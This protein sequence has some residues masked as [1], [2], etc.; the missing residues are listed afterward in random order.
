MAG[1]QSS[2]DEN[3]TGRTIRK[4]IAALAAFLAVT[5][6]N[7]LYQIRGESTMFSNSVLALLAFGAFL[8]LGLRFFQER[9]S[10]R[11]AVF[12]LA[13]GFLFAAL[14]AFGFSLNYT[15]TI[16]NP[17]VFP[18]L[19]CL[20]PFF[21]VCTGFGL[22]AL[23]GGG[24]Q[25]KENGLWLAKLSDRQFYL[26]C[27]SAL[28][29]AW[30]PVLLAAWPGIFSYDCG[31]Q[32]AAFVDG[33][34]TG[35]HP[36]LH[37]ALLGVTRTLGHALSGGG[38]AGNQM[39]ALLY[40]L[41]QMAA[42]SLLYADVCLFLRQR[43]TPRWLQLGSLLFLGFHPVNSLMALCA[44]KDSL[45]TAVFAAFI[46]RLFRMAEDREAFFS[47]WKKQA[48]FCVNVFF[49]F[50]LRNNGFH[51]FLLAV[52][53]LLFAFRRFWKR[54]LLLVVICLG[55]YGI[56]NGPVYGALGIEP[57]DPREMCSVLMQSA[58][59]VWSLDNQGLTEE[60]KEAFRSII[61]EEGLNSYLSRFADPVKAYFNGKKFAADPGPFLKAWLSAGM[62]HK[63]MYIDAFLANTFGY[64][65]PGN[66]IEETDKGKDYFEYC[67][68]DFREDIDV[69][70]ESK[71]PALSEFYRRIGNESSFQKVPVISAL[72]NLG[73]Y[74]WLWLFACLLALYGKQWR[75]A[76][77][78]VPFGAYFLTNLLGP[79]VK[80][81][82]HYPFIACAPLLI[83]FIWTAW[84]KDGSG[85]S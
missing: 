19:L 72:F 11:L 55:L 52:P 28:F 4:S 12:S 67:C 66:S 41:V 17:E 68:K 3:R 53:F 46:L 16:W 56:Y 48:L 2:W 57:S 33:E 76:W 58:A 15:D 78:L 59:R 24:V 23:S 31:W 47:S 1:R 39:G 32:L 77:V 43:R 13:G 82:Y 75:R 64:W 20:T 37:T 79:V 38:Q 44:T 14:A 21:G 81:R 25:K 8:Y 5:G 61:D 9:V 42:M 51:T 27:A 73:A 85:L 10:R 65:Y 62:R 35:H 69:E 50:A 80:M 7:L 18:A 40:S 71:L 49:L 30:V 26:L 60:E 36:I 54:M 34:V 22:R 45:F 6:F 74:T 84:R 70:M 29:L 63:K 83:Y